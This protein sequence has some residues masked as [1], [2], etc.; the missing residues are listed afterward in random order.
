MSKYEIKS[1]KVTFKSFSKNLRIVLPLIDEKTKKK[2]VVQFYA[3]PNVKGGGMYIL[4]KKIPKDKVLYDALIE[5]R[6]RSD[7]PCPFETQED[8]MNKRMKESII[9]DLPEGNLEVTKE[10]LVELMR[11][12]KELDELK[13]SKPKEK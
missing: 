5:W 9:V 7:A 10:Q 2:T 6:D 8:W 11:K 3:D 12:E 4:D 1:D 13:K